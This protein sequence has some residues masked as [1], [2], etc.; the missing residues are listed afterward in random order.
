[1]N[2]SLGM[3]GQSLISPA[4]LKRWGQNT[5]TPLLQFVDQQLPAFGSLSA[6]MNQTVRGHYFICRACNLICVRLTRLS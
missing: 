3:P 2:D 6:A 4:Y 5:M 1:L